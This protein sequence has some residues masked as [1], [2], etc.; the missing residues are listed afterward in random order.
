MPFQQSISPFVI[1]SEKDY[2]WETVRLYLK[3]QIQIKDPFMSQLWPTLQHTNWVL[4]HPSTTSN[5]K[6][7]TPSGKSYIIRSWLALAYPWKNKYS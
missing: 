1:Q 6:D 4:W 5:F 3:I 2:V 7:N